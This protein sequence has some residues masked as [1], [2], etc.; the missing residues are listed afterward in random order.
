M[1]HPSADLGLMVIGAVGMH[2]FEFAQ[3]CVQ[4]EYEVNYDHVDADG[5]SSTKV[6]EKLSQK[7][8]EQDE[9]E[10]NYAVR[11]KSSFTCLKELFQIVSAIL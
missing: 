10:E 8:E 4:N 3:K 6:G 11:S 5:L 7:R 9:H 2:D 1:P